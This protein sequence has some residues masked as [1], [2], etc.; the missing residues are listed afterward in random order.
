VSRRREYAP[1]SVSGFDS[2]AVEDEDDQQE[3]DAAGKARARI[4]EVA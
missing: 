4:L 1:V 3:S 2:G